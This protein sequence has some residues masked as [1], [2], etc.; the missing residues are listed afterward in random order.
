M[1]LI[2]CPEC[3]REIS[4]KVKACPHCGYPFESSPDN[5]DAQKV[6]ITSVNI[7]PRDPQKTKKILSVVGAV[8][9]LIVVAFAAYTFISMNQEKEAFNT[10]VDNLNRANQTMIT[11]ASDSETFLN[12]TARVWRD[13]IYEER[14]PET[15]KYTMT[16]GSFHD[17]FNISLGKLFADAETEAT[18]SG[19]QDNQELVEGIMK[20]LQNPPEGLE[21]CYDTV[22]DLYSAYQGLTGLA[23][24]PSGSL[25]S[26][27]ENKNS[28]IDKFLELYKKLESQIPEKK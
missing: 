1:A 8:V 19:I 12:L 3:N 16:G 14:D 17:D 5:D 15:Q 28:K 13:S 23:I 9:I 2:L 27:S 10:Y 21:K 6:E 20:E 4:D 22:T 18:I 24:N 26:F 11:G 7:Q 25:Q